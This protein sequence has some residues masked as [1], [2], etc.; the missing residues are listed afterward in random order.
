MTQFN[1]NDAIANAQQD[2]VSKA[3]YTAGRTIW[4]TFQKSGFHLYPA[5]ST[6]SSL[7]DVSYLGQRHRHLF[8]F[9]VS[10]EVFHN[11][12]DLEF[13]QVLNY[14]ESLFGNNID[15]NHKSVEML[16]E[17]LYKHLIIRYPDRKMSIEVSEDGECGCLIQFQG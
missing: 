17:D 12:R 1:V 15:I 7:S 11:D 10:I 13:H 5:A 3:L 9:K 4:V 14:C 6:D 8:K 2:K 16:A